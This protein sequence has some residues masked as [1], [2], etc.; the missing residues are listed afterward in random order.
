R[1]AQPRARRWES[2]TSLARFATALAA[3]S[4]L[5]LGCD[6]P[7]PTQRDAGV[8][9]GLDL[10]ARVF[11][12]GTVFCETDADCDD[13]VSCTEDSCLA[14]G[15]CRNAVQPS[16]C[17]DGVFCNGR[18]IC[19]PQRGCLPAP[20]RETCN[21]DNVCTIDRCDEETD[22]CEH[23]PR[24]LDGDGDV[25]FFC[26]PAG[27]EGG[28]CDDRDP[29]VSSLRSEVCD[30]FV[31][32]DCDGEIDEGECG[33]PPN[34]VCADPLDIS[35]GGSF[36]LNTSGANPDY[37]T[38]CSTVMRRDLVASFTLTEARS[39]SIEG[40]GEFFTVY[41]SLRSECDDLASEIACQSGFP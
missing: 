34:D 35:A 18:E 33:G 10:D 17:D 11:P 7:L 2:M 29:T 1:A 27:E 3:L 9:A 24:D 40:Q 21:D 32:N 5:G 14:A 39:V 16:A 37:T 25:D 4:L 6:G 30:D 8:D 41:L 20:V 38:S 13:G 26:V 12:D 15:I 19:D 31:D 36:L 22:S 28:D 23:F